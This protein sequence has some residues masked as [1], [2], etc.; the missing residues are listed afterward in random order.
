MLKR[1]CYV[2]F[3]LSIFILLTSC[4]SGNSQGTLKIYPDYIAKG[5]VEI[6][7]NKMVSKYFFSEQRVDGK[8]NAEF[9]KDKR[10]IKITKEN[11]RVILEG[12][13]LKNVAEDIF[14]EYYIDKL[15]NSE[16]YSIVKQ[17]KS[18]I[19]TVELKGDIRYIH[20]YFENE[21][22]KKIAVI[23]QDA[24]FIKT[25]YLTEYKKYRKG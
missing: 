24:R 19:I 22:L 5:F 2:F 1:F 14:L 17:E 6:T 20:Y 11:G 18:T 16:K 9:Q 15:I 8:V 21:S 4:K 12:K 7:S 13:D 10:K 23:Y 3:V 25:I